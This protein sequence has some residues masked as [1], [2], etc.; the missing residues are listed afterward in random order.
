MTKPNGKFRESH[1]PSRAPHWNQWKFWW[2]F[3]IVWSGTNT[4]RNHVVGICLFVGGTN[5]WLIAKSNRDQSSNRFDFKWQNQCPTFSENLAPLF[6]SI[7]WPCPNFVLNSLRL[8]IGLKVGS[9]VCVFV[10]LYVYVCQQCVWLG[11]QLRWHD[12]NIPDWKPLRTYIL[13]LYWSPKFYFVSSQD[14]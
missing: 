12:P 7:F 5:L 14:S 11:K 9:Y 2:F 4:S 13:F 10:C 1:M 3:N 6:L 8:Y